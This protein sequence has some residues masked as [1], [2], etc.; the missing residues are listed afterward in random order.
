VALIILKALAEPNEL[1]PPLSIA[2]AAMSHQIV[3]GQISLLQR[4]RK[5]KV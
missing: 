2:F 5:F 3:P 4:G 1:T